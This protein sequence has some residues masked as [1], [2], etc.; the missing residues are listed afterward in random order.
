M[1]VRD[2]ALPPQH[3]LPPTPVSHRVRGGG[4]PPHEPKDGCWAGEEARQPHEPHSAYG[5]EL[6]GGWG[7]G[8]PGGQSRSGDGLRVLG[9]CS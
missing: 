8:T 5:A 6:W 9:A 4:C 1:W 7:G 2:G 3:N